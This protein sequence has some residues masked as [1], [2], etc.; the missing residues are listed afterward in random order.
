MIVR[1]RRQLG[2][3]TAAGAQLVLVAV[4]AHLHSW[5]GWMICLSLI[6][7]AGLLGWISAQGHRR[8]IADTP[9][10]HIASAAQGYVELRGIGKALAGEPLISP[11]RGMR[12]LWYRYQVEQRSGENSW[13]TIDSGESDASFIL[14]DGTGQCVIDVDGAEILTTHKETWGQGDYRNTE[15]T[16][17]IGD[18]TYALGEFRTIGVGDVELSVNE[19]V[20]A[21]LAEWKKDRPALLKRFDLDGNGVIDLKEWELARQAARREV[22]AMHRQARATPDLNTLC[23]P[24]GGQMFLLSNFDPDRLARHYLWWSLYHLAV[25]FG[26]LAALPM[27]WRHGA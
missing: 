1:W 3:A 23:R 6:A 14:D 18:S 10:S 11:L 15:W 7:L 16:L 2:Q 8:A 27:V 25:F 4:A 21:L 9:T 22:V 5:T 19:D 17:L 13:K 26:V 12:C 24:A 20:S